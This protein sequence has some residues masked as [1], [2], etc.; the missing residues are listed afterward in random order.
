MFQSGDVE[1]EQWL[2]G[3]TPEALI[4]SNLEV[5]SPWTGETV[6]PARTH[7]VGGRVIP[8]FNF[9]TCGVYLSARREAL[10]FEADV[11]LLR[12][13][14]G[15]YRIRLDTGHKEL[16]LPVSTTLLGSYDRVESMASLDDRF[17]VFGLRQEVRGPT[18]VGV[19]VHDLATRER[20]F[21]ERLCAGYTCADPQ[22]VAGHDGHFALA[23]RDQKAQ[24][25]VL[26]HYRVMP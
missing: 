19:A 9:S 17:A 25:H 20:V 26:I 3:A 23:Y 16:W 22:V 7:A 8:D 14:G 2:I 1:I 18:P 10:V 13:Q 4:L 21:N 12:R 24:E 6:L 15:V 11:T 5:W